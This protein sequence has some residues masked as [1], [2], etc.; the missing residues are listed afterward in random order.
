MNGHGRA[1][2]GGEEGASPAARSAH[3]LRVA[4][5]AL[6]AAAALAVGGCATLVPKLETPKLEVVGVEVLDA[7]FTQQ[8]FNVRM[9]VQ[10]P[11]DRALPIRGLRYTMQLAGEPFGEG[12]SN[13]AFT[14]PALGEAEF[15]MTVTT[16]LAT[17]LLK[18]L[19]KLERNGGA[20]EY[21]LQGT[22]E[23][24]W[25]FLRSI[26]F[27]ETGRLPTRR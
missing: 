24:D 11:N 19:P 5:L 16:N 21:R 9:R 8:R 27:T 2:I 15:D 7:Q 1:G 4:A 12:A 10:N 14:V 3:G 26:P 18:I 13:K 23:T 20:L 25:K 17:S 6:C 22:V